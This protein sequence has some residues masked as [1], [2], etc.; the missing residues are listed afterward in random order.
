MSFTAFTVADGPK[1]DDELALLSLLT[2]GRGNFIHPCDKV[3]YV[4]DIIPLTENEFKKN[5]VLLPLPGEEAQ[6]T[7]ISFPRQDLR[8]LHFLQSC[9]S[10]AG[11][12]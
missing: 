5:I 12:S 10:I 11:Q 6:F 8:I 1:I 9:C 7:F 3:S 2:I 4:G